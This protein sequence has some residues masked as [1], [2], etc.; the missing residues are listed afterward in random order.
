MDFILSPIY[1][2]R[3]YTITVVYTNGYCREETKST[4]TVNKLH[5]KIISPEIS[6]KNKVLTVK[7]KLVDSTDSL[8][9]YNTS[10]VSFKIN[11]N[12]ACFFAK[13]VIIKRHGG[14]SYRLQI[15]TENR[16][17]KASPQNFTGIR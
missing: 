2:P 15:F 10:V 7:A 13:L 8:I 17:S 16:K 14:L 11:G 4:L 9:K 3:N 5:A 12:I 1:S 6:V